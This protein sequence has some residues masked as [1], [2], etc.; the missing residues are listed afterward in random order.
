MTKAIHRP[1]ARSEKIANMWMS[2]RMMWNM[3]CGNANMMMARSGAGVRHGKSA[4]LLVLVRHFVGTQ[5]NHA[6]MGS[7]KN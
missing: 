3:I 5:K 1:G 2:L 6:G 7:M 4:K